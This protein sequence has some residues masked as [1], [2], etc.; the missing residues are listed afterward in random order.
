MMT[1]IRIL[2]LF[3]VTLT[4]SKTNAGKCKCGKISADINPHSKYQPRSSNSRIWGG[5]NVT[6]V[7]RYPWH[8]LLRFTFE[9]MQ[10][11]SS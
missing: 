8:I 4:F 2:M 7:G 10:G 1:Q 9:D 3:I 5:M 11:I 6:E